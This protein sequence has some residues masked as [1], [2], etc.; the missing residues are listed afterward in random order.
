MIELRNEREERG[1]MTAGLVGIAPAA[2]AV[3]TEPLNM[4]RTLY[5][6]RYPG[7]HNVAFYVK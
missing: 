2:P 5:K 1:E 6:V 7:T 3:R 4:R